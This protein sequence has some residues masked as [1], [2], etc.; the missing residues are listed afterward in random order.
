MQMLDKRDNKIYEVY[1]ITYDSNGYPQFLVYK[2]G[3]WYRLSAKHFK[4]FIEIEID[5]SEWFL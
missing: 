5:D 4:P 1:D 3:E 2:N